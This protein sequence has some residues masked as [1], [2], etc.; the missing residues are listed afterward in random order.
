MLKRLLL[1]LVSD[2]GKKSR[3]C[4]IQDLL[5]G[6]VTEVE[7]INGLVVKKGKEVNVPTPLNEAVNS[8]IKQLEEGKRKPGPSNL[9]VL[10]QSI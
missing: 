2:V 9:E 5:K 3:T 7:Y 6:R 10:C 8:L 4:I 1:N